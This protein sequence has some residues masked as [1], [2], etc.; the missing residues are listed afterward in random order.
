MRL[1][2]PPIHPQQ[3]YSEGFWY[4][5]LAA[6]MYL[7]AAVL[8]MA[9][10]L[11]YFLGHFP[12][13]FELTEPQRTLI[14]Q[15]MM[16]FVWLAAGA[17]VFSKVESRFGQID[18]GY[19]WSF[20][21]ALYFADVTILTVGFGDLACTSNLGRGLIFPYSVGGIIMIG[22]VISSISRFVTELGTGKVAARHKE[23]SR[24]KTVSKALA[25]D[26]ELRL[27]ANKH[28]SRLSS[29]ISATFPKRVITTSS[30]GP[31]NLIR[32]GAKETVEAVV[33]HKR[34][35]SKLVLLH[36]EKDRFVAMRAIEDATQKWKK[37]TALSISI[38]CFA[39]VWLLGAMVFYYA[40]KETRNMTYFQALYF[41]YVS[42]LT[43]GYGDL[44]PISNVG[45]PFFV[46]WSLIAVPTMTILVS[47]MGDTVVQAFRRA[48]DIFADF[49]LLPKSGK[50]RDLLN[51]HSWLLVFIQGFQDAR[52][53]RS[54]RKKKEQGFAIGGGDAQED[55][56]DLSPTSLE[57][58]CHSPN[59]VTLEKEAEKTDQVG[60]I[61]HVDDPI[62]LGQKLAAAIHRVALD[63]RES[64]PKRYCYEDWVEFTKLIK[65]TGKQ[66]PIGR[67]WQENLSQNQ[68]DGKAGTLYVDD[69]YEYDDEEEKDEIIDWDW[70]GENSP[71]MGRQSEPEFVMDRLCESMRRYLA[72]PITSYSRPD[73]RGEAT[74]SS[75]DN[76]IG[77]RKVDGP[78]YLQIPRQ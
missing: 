54:L 41:C 6:A 56:D 13:K 52:A 76:S 37:W 35:R 51:R 14:L 30:Y 3:T 10:M 43:I 24:A 46:V 62:I 8:L 77:K 33:P 59:F 75:K 22:L 47:A 78:K 28:R 27:Q 42:L 67:V 34:K 4:A 18:N 40:E 73:V 66:R 50:W 9:N 7:I 53:H 45:R 69:K 11:G 23:H 38:A 44:A 17:A 55:G 20:T 57:A 5:V 1:H 71:L 25:I 70:I 32:R 15:T 65:F 72:R 36:E 19:N 48:T 74:E 39:I 29:K 16:L 31:L 68:D 26:Q 63:L 64:P 58:W 61:S 2:A 49:T 12:Q 60:G 21:N